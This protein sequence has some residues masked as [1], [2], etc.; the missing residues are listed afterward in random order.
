MVLAELLQGRIEAFHLL[1]TFAVRHRVEITGEIDNSFAGQM[2]LVD[3]MHALPR[4]AAVPIHEQVVHDAAQPGSRLL[5]FYELIEFA[6]C[7]YQAG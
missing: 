3:K 1:D 6:E 2:P 7:L 4:E 5:D